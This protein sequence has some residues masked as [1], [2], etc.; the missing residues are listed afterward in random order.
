MISRSYSMAMMTA[1]TESQ[2]YSQIMFHGSCQ[3]MSRLLPHRGICEGHPLGP[4][5]YMTPSFEVAARYAREPGGVHELLLPLVPTTSDVL[6]NLDSTLDD[7]PLAVQALTRRHLARDPHA[8]TPHLSAAMDFLPLYTRLANQRPDYIPALISAG[9]WG[10]MSHMP[11]S[12]SSGAMDR[13]L[14][15][16]CLMPE[17]IQLGS[18]TP[19]SN[20]FSSPHPH[21]Y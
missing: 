7:Q 13:G 14:Q 20:L 10:C 16:I 15:I 11:P 21:P 18:F 19:A 5:L 1:D 9:V 8:A 2:A 12:L 4:G 17:T 3:R 6:L